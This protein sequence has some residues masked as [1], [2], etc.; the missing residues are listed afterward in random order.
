MFQTY[1]Q[2]RIRELL[3]QH[4]SKAT[5]TVCT[6]PVPRRGI[7]SAS[8]YLAWLDFV[9]K[10]LPPVLFLRGNQQSVLTFYS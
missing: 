1:R 7:L 9:S 2:L 3:L 10:D 8:L 4:S 5:L 6:L